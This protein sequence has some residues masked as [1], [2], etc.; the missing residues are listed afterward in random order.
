MEHRKRTNQRQRKAEQL[1][2][3]NGVAEP[4]SASERERLTK[5][6]EEEVKAK[7]QD[8]S[9]RTAAPHIHWLN[10]DIIQQGDPYYMD[11]H[12]RGIPL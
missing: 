10:Q 12:T 5:P 3:E 11:I 6:K 1:P 8:L 4:E 9:A 7:G 2:I